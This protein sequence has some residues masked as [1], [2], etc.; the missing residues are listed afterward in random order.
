MVSA[1]RSQ[2]SLDDAV[3]LHPE[4]EFKLIVPAPAAL[5]TLAFPGLTL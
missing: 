3:Q 4:G 1:G 5:P 2:V